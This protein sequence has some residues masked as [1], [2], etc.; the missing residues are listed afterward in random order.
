MTQLKEIAGIIDDARLN[1]HF[2]LE[3]GHVY[4]WICQIWFGRYD[5]LDKRII[6]KGQSE[7]LSRLLSEAEVTLKKWYD[8][9]LIYDVKT[10]KLFYDPNG[11]GHGE[12]LST[13]KHM[14]EIIESSINGENDD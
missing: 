10:D 6:Y 12:E 4:D 8:E 14:G 9:H 11:D 5:V 7:D 1:L 2:N 13:G 3:Y